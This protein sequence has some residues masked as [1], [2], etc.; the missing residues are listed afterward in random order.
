MHKSNV[1]TCVQSTKVW[2]DKEWLHDRFLLLSFHVTVYRIL[3]WPKTL[4]PT[5]R[6]PSLWDPLPTRSTESC[7]HGAMLT[8]ISH[9]SSSFCAKRKASEGGSWRCCYHRLLH[10][11]QIHTPQWPLSQYAQERLRPCSE[12]QICSP[13]IIMYFYTCTL[14]ALGE[15]IVV[16]LS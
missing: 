1:S 9:P 12:A 7:A 5:Q 2:N 16:L 14:V 6:P 3:V 11:P 13:I 10:T 15:F 8:R 4:P